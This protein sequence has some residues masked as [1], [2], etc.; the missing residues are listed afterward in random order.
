MAENNLEESILKSDDQEEEEVQ[1]EEKPEPKPKK[2]LTEKQ[3]EA[4]AKGREIRH[5]NLREMKE[6]KMKLKQVEYQEYNPP[7]K[8]IKKKSHKE[9]MAEKKEKLEQLQMQKQYE[10]EEIRLNKLIETERNKK[11][12]PPQT[13]KPIEKPKRRIIFG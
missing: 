3:K 7:D 2:K 10:L 6:N 11:I 9:T 13:E 4:F 1:E 12:E 5:K 8:V